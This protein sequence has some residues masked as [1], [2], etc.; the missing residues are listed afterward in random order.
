MPQVKKKK[1]SEVLKWRK[2]VGSQQI[3]A[4][5]SGVSLSSCVLGGWLEPLFVLS[6]R[7]IWSPDLLYLGGI[8][9][10]S[11]CCW[12]RAEQNLQLQERPSESTGDPSAAWS[13]AE[14]AQGPQRLRAGGPL[15]SCRGEKVVEGSPCGCV[16]TRPSAQASLRSQLGSSRGRIRCVPAPPPL[17]TGWRHRAALLGRRRSELTAHSTGILWPGT[18]PPCPAWDSSSCHPR[19]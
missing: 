17:V 8:S 3:L 11:G 18:Q 16:P 7:S 15:G 14:G 19:G 4:P 13:W 12:L 6:F 10:W 9:A 2:G 1:S 5:T